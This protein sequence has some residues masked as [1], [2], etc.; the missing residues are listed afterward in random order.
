MKYIFLF[1]DD[2]VDGIKKGLEKVINMPRYSV[3]SMGKEAQMFV[4]KE[5]NKENQAMKMIALFDKKDWL[6]R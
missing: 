1:P 5:K 6:V 4:R 2:S 3:E